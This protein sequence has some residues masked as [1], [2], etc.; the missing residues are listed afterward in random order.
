MDNVMNFPR[1]DERLSNMKDDMG[2]TRSPV[3]ATEQQQIEV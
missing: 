1:E 2:F 3:G